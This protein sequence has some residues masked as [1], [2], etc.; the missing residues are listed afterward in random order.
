M[1]TIQGTLLL[2]AIVL[3]ASSSSGVM[4]A[5]FG[6]P[7]YF[8]DTCSVVINPGPTCDS[9]ECATRCARQYRGGVGDCIRT[10]CRCVYTCAFPPSAATN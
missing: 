8:Q 1:K 3:V 10:K 5:R 6:G 9:G 7:K 4:A 2:L